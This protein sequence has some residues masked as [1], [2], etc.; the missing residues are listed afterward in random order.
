MKALMIGG[1][2][3]LLA[4]SGCA[5]KPAPGARTASAV[6]V[7]SAALEIHPAEQRSE[8]LDLLLL[9]EGENTVPPRRLVAVDQ[10]AIP[11]RG[12]VPTID[13]WG[14]RYPD[15]AR[16]LGD[17]ALG[18][19]ETARRLTAW[20]EAHP[21]QMETLVNWAISA[22]S[23]PL[24]GFLLDRSSW[25]DL[26]RIDATDRVGVEAFLLWIRS[27]PRAATELTEHDGSLAFALQHRLTGGPI[28]SP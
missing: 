19:P 20:Q 3:A 25:D 23:E 16:A 26:R 6:A 5:S 1:L 2:A 11:A 17:W 28:A 21:E 24:G 10:S 22:V 12:E 13:R 18:H 9:G 8:P 14:T 4:A 15:A 7:T 27:S